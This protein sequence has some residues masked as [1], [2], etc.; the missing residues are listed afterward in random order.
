VGKCVRTEETCTRWQE[1]RLSVFIIFEWQRLNFGGG[2]VF[3]VL[4][5]VSTI[6]FLLRM[7]GD[8]ESIGLV[9]LRVFSSYF[10]LKIGRILL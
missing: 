10:C 3:N 9:R 7:T 6:I 1:L 8:D 2:F 4:V 5:K